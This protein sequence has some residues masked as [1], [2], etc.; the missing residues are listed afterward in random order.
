MD[1]PC[2]AARNRACWSGQINM[3][4]G[5]FG[6]NSTSLIEAKASMP[7]TAPPYRCAASRIENWGHHKRLSE[8]VASARAT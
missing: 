2:P 4:E 7:M 3:G 5:G 6:F 1:F 8:T